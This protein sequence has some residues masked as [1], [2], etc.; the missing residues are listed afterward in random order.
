M[1]KNI[2]FDV[3]LDMYKLALELSKTNIALLYELSHY[4]VDNLI[5][6]LCIILAK[7]KGI[8]YSNPR[9]FTLSFDN[10]YKKILMAHFNVPNYEREVKALHKQRNIFTHDSKSITYNIRKNFVQGYVKIAEAI[11]REI[12]IIDKKE[13]FHTSYIKDIY[14]DSKINSQI[15]KIHV[16]N[17]SDYNGIDK[18]RGLLKTAESEFENILKERLIPPELEMR[19]YVCPI[20]YRSQMFGI[21]ESIRQDFINNSSRGPLIN[22]RY[23]A[24][25]FKD[26]NVNRDGYFYINNHPIGGNIFIRKDG[27]ILYSW[28]YRDI[29]KKILKRPIDNKDFSLYTGLLLPFVEMVGFFIAFLNFIHYFS[30]RLTYKDNYL[31]IFKV[32]GIKSFG[33]SKITTIQVDKSVVKEY[34]HSEFEPVEEICSFQ[35]NLK[36]N[37]LRLIRNIFNEIL[38]GYGDSGGIKISKEFQDSLF[39][40]I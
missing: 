38:F 22:G 4:L 17:S 16:Q 26:L 1:S 27:I 32:K 28:D 33:Y 5:S 39:K 12:G 18:I 13:I 30:R 11:L 6:K 36:E 37:S 10:L 34:Q 31:L 21:D 9:G 15:S 8:L 14:L 40:K 7:E 25:V 29:A 2:E 19:I 23:H 3:I 35:E 20:D 24:E